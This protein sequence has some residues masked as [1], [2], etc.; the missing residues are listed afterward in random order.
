VGRFVI[1]AEAFVRAAMRMSATGG[2][3]HP[4]VAHQIEHRGFFCELHR[5]VNRQ[6][7]H[8]YAEAQSFGSLGNCAEHD[9]RR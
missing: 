7:I 2:K 6:S 5:V 8:G 4:A 9:V 1:R 3:L